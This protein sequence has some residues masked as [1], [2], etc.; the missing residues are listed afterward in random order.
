MSG[1]TVTFG[2]ENPEAKAAI[3]REFRVAQWLFAAHWEYERRA[4]AEA[5]LG[6]GGQEY[7]RRSS[8]GARWA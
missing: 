2:R 7:V 5:L 3:G 8:T 6:L 1:A 4:T